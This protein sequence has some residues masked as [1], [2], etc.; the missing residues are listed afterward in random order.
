MTWRTPS[1]GPLAT[2]ANTAPA[3]VLREALARLHAGAFG[4]AAALVEPLH[5]A[6][7][8]A[9]EAR[10][11]LGL[12]LGGSGHPGR[13]AALLDAVARQR[14]DSPHP[15]QDLAMLLRR[16]QRPEAAAAYFAAAR[17]LAPEDHRLA[18][19]MGEWAQATGQAEAARHAFEQAAAL[20]P[21]LPAAQIGLAVLE[22]EAGR[23]DAAIDRLQQVVARDPAKVEALS[24]L[25][26]LLG[27]EGRFPE[28]FACFEQAGRVAPGRLDVD[29]NHGH[30]LL[31]AGCLQEGW[32]PFHRR[33]EQPGRTLLPPR[34]LLPV[35][36]PGQR[37]DGKV[38]VVTYD[39][40]FGDTLQFARYVPRLAAAGA[41][42]LLWAP[43]PLRRL[44]A[45]MPGVARVL[46]GDVTLPRFDWHCPIMRLGQ[47]FGTTLDTIPAG[48]PY[49]AP[50]PA[51]A[52][53]WSARL[54]APS[55]ARRIGLVWAGAPKTPFDARRS[56]ALAELAS[57]AAVRACSGSACRWAT[58]AP[59]RRP[60]G[61]LYMT[62]WAR[63]RTSPTPPRSSPD[64]T[65]WSAWTRR[66]CIWPAPWA[67]R[68]CC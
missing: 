32:A 22:A 44:L 52:A 39:S 25:G 19:A 28:A 56:L 53:A 11:L 9:L 31:K 10:L 65:Q 8:E 43:E 26:V 50:D 42:V 4:Q 13:A 30:A 61:S 58:H 62:R 66:P 34:L 55:G 29:V 5:R 40:G 67:N 1:E 18:V 57:L 14:P 45:A 48:I 68:C 21:D 46:S 17:A 64:S 15:A 38:V 12:A 49:L 36:S 35:L 47:V 51:L 2:D 37:L 27:V 60:P 23:L 7:P 24:N 33:L 63:C 20:Q 54:P 59:R 16:V 6:R 41:Q 3:D